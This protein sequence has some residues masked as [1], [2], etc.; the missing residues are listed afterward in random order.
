VSEL[1]V[2]GRR[3]KGPGLLRTAS[4]LAQHLRGTSAE[5]M[6]GGHTPRIRILP[7]LL[8]PIQ[9]TFM[10]EITEP[11][12]EA[13]LRRAA[14]EGVDVRRAEVA[15]ASEELEYLNVPDGQFDA[16]SRLRS[17]PS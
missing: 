4:A 3:K 8:R 15:I 10:K 6:H 7:L 13:R 2:S 17:L 1:L 5:F 11:F 16:S 9:I 14:H 12:L